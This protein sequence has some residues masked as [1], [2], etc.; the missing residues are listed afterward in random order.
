MWLNVLIVVSVGLLGYGL[1]VYF[2]HSVQAQPNIVEVPPKEDIS[3][4]K[5]QEVPAFS[6]TDIEG[7][8]HDI[9]DFKG[10]IVILNFW[11]SWCAPC[12]KEFP[13]LLDLAKSFEKNA[14]L[15]ALSSD[16][17]EEPMNRFLNKIDLHSN[18]Y[19]AMDEDVKVTNGIFGTFRLPETF[20]IDQD[21]K[22]VRKIVG[23]D[24]SKQEL[25]MF[26]RRLLF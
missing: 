14:V 3:V 23:A 7:K 12:I 4:Q 16:Q 6:F 2:D 21:Q 24:W 26:L 9:R 25:G 8:T 10:K 11:A 18:V 20:I 19:V 22:L 13:D 1:T 15:I 5:D 17:E